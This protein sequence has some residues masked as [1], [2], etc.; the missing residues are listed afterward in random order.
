MAISGINTPLQGYDNHLNTNST[1]KT[2]AVRDAGLYKG[3]VD[4]CAAG[5]CVTVNTGDAGIT[6]N[7]IDAFSR[8]FH[9]FIV[10]NPGADLTSSGTAVLS[11]A[12]GGSPQDENIVR[13]TSQFVGYNLPRG[14]NNDQVRTIIY[15]GS[16]SQI[17]L[18]DSTAGR[19]DSVWSRDK[20]PETEYTM[21]LNMDWKDHRTNPSGL[22][23]T[24]IHEYLH[25]Q[26][27]L[28]FS[29]GGR[30]TN[31]HQ[32]LDEKARGL[33]HDYGL[34]GSGCQ[35]VGDSLLPMLFSPDYPGCH[36]K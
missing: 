17:Q 26:D 24:M 22:A 29:G 28:G 36:T 7:Q 12:R 25:R 1:V 6:Q 10:K 3:K 21:R 34:G 23:R 9:E 18:P 4:I 33:L 20:T 11:S 5:S 2:A 8:A 13:I 30:V 14:W 27:E 32:A 19:L 35:S 16:A 15:A 31:A